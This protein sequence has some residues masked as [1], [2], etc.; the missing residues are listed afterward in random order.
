MKYVTEKENQGKIYV[1]EFFELCKTV[2]NLKLE[3]ELMEDYFPYFLANKSNIIM[4]CIEKNKVEPLIDK[5]CEGKLDEILNFDNSKNFHEIKKRDEKIK[6]LNDQYKNII[7]QKDEELKKIIQQLKEKEDALK[8]KDEEIKKIIGRLE[9]YENSIKSKDNNNKK[10]SKDHLC[11]KLENKFNYEIYLDEKKKEI[12][13]IKANM[14]INTIE[15][16][17]NN[18]IIF[19]NGHVFYIIIPENFFKEKNYKDIKIEY[20]FDFFNAFFNNK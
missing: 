3:K 9:D 10:N 1:N 4:G 13:K 17:T 14:P 11:F 6:Q 12:S 5:I 15:I 19:N 8:K 2:N 16:K 20:E 18:D 7:K